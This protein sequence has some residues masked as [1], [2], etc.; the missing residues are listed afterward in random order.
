MGNKNTIS[1][2]IK[3]S[4]MK[5]AVDQVKDEEGFNKLTKLYQSYTNIIDK[6]RLLGQLGQIQNNLKQNVIDWTL[7]NVDTQDQIYGMASIQRSNIFGSHL[8]SEWFMGYKK[9]L[10]EKYGSATMLLENFY[11]VCF[12]G[13]KNEVLLQKS[14]EWL[15]NDNDKRYVKTISQCKEEINNSYQV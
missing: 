14:L 7:K 9:T 4:V 13:I 8:I 6:N 11:R 1:D 15:D 12:R 2:D 10:S 3:S 5:Y